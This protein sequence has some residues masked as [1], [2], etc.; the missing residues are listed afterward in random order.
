MK[1]EEEIGKELVTHREF[2]LMKRNI[3]EL[4][5]TNLSGEKLGMKNLLTL[6]VPSGGSRMWVL[7][8]KGEEIEVKMFEG[9]IIHTSCFRIYWEKDFDDPTGG[10]GLPP[11]CIS[12]DM[13]TGVGIP[14]GEC[15]ECPFQEFGSSGRGK[16]CNEKRTMFF[17]A[18][19]NLFPVVVMVPPSS[20]EAAKNYLIEL[21]SEHFLPMNSLY[22][23]LTLEKVVNKEGIPYS[24]IKFK[25][26]AQVK[27]IEQVMEEIKGILPMLS[28][29]DLEIAKSEKGKDDFG[30]QV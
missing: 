4:I 14:G 28:G 30:E 13:I 19:N 16:K 7:P 18:E 21:T 29:I 20:L 23:E 12:T 9:I 10:A 22:T 3:M 24:Q 8:S 11:D 2:P 26:G 1:K 15:A 17:K 6:K 25:A 27:N 5:K